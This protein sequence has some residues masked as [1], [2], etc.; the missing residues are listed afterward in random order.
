L[1]LRAIA[2][3]M[4]MTSS[5]LYRYFASREQLLIALTADGFASLAD[6]LEQAE[7]EILQRDHTAGERFMQIMRAYRQWSLSHPTEYALTFGTPVPGVQ[8]MSEQV[9]AEMFR[10]VEVLFRVMVTGMKR[11][12]IH[13]RGLPGRDEPG[14]RAR[15]EGFASAVDEALTPEAMAGCMFVWT[16]LH[17]AISLELFGHMPPPLLPVDALFDKQ[18]LQ[19]LEVLGYEV[20]R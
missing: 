17:G 6:A 13:P 3:D 2:R 8:P 5:A 12:A 14:L 4:G 7:A 16:H 9:K 19:V 10:G 11:G 15:L 20:G 18:M 1:S